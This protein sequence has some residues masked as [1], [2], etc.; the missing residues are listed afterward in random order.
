M[1]AIGTPQTLALPSPLWGRGEGGEGAE[2]A[3]QAGI[4][5]QIA[6]RLKAS[7]PFAESKN[8]RA[9]KRRG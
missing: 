6:L 5:P 2:I 4:N 7:L 3:D 9:E 8:P 1:L